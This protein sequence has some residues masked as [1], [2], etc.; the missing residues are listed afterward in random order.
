MT[1]RGH[2][3]TDGATDLI[4]EMIASYK[5]A[6]ESEVKGNRLLWVYSSYSA[7]KGFDPFD[8]RQD[9][10]V[11]VIW[12]MLAVAY[13]E[14]GKFQEAAEAYEGA[15]KI[16]PTNEWLWEKLA[17]LHEVTGASGKAEEAWTKAEVVGD[18]FA[19]RFIPQS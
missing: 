14:D 2:G 19:R 4:K 13:K 5:T 1:L 6:L 9:L 18:S 3:D 7:S 12:V 15:L 8:N 10:P 16:L 17:E 11:E